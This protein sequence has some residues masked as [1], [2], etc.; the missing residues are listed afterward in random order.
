MPDKPI[1]IFP[2]AIVAARKTLPQSFGPPGPR[3]T[4][5]QQRARLANRFQALSQQFGTVQANAGG[6]DP[7]QVVVFETVGSVEDFQRVVKRIPGMEWLGDF[8][9]EIAEPDPGF[10][11]DGQEQPSMPGRLFVLAG[12]R[13]AYNEVLRLWRAWSRDPNEKLPRPYGSLATVFKHLQDVRPWE[14]KDR[15]A[16][17]GV[18]AS[19]ERGLTSNDPAIRFEAELW[20][21]ADPAK[22][23]EA[24]ARFQTTVGEAGGQCIKQAIFPEIDYH[25]V[26]LELPATAVRQTVA[27][28]NAGNYTKLLRLTDVKYFTPFGQAAIMPSSD[29]SPTSAARKTLPTGDP[30]AALLDGLPLTNHAV[31]QGRL[32]VDDPDNLAAQYQAGEHRHG[33][34]MAS[35]ITHGELDANEPAISSKLY[36]RPLM[37]PGRPDASN[38]RWETFP[39]DELALDI[40]HRA[41]KRI[42]E[43]DDDEP[44]QASSVKVI[45]LSL[46]DTFQPFDRQLSPWARLLDWLAWKYQVLFVVSAGNHPL[47]VSIPVPPNAVAGMADDDLRGH[48]LRAMAHQKVQRR[49][50]APAESVNAL[51]V[52]ALHAQAT[53]PVNAGRLVDLLRGSGFPSPVN[54]V[55]SGY[56]RAIK[57]EILVP[58][59]RQHHSPKLLG[60]PSQTAEFEIP[61]AISQ[62]G[63]SVAAPGGTAVPPTNAVRTVGTSN[64]AALTTRRAAQFVDEIGQLRQEEGGDL[65]SDTYTAVILKAM[66][67][68]GATWGNWQTF[69][70]QTF[71]GPDNGVERWWRIKRACAQFFGYGMAD[72]ER[73]TICTDQRVIVLGCGELSADQGHVYQVPIPPALN[74]Q[75]IQRRT[76]VTLAWMTP[77]NP[78][79]RNYCMADLWFDLPNSEALQIKRS[80]ASDKM[81]RQG[82][83]QHELFEGDAAVPI[84][85]GDTL[86][87]HVSCRSDAGNKLTTPIPYA[88]M[89]SLETSRPLAVSVYEQVK[90]ALD[91]LRAAAR[92]RSGVRAGRPRR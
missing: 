10:L 74:A 40:V 28:I 86:S 53:A 63:Q 90:V 19:W 26:L 61:R 65:L 38:R 62:P 47:D 56:R 15:I 45:N 82:T 57:P 83:V 18:V 85:E 72:F 3:P 75:R 7:E 52:A 51:T 37:C 8:E 34:A 77:T 41:V 87:I 54:C 50:L 5:S 79:H 68:H 30:V 44:A 17:T 32:V 21:R 42:M 49:L 58:G 20:C 35:L 9:A 2:A 43:G 78:R 71:D 92:V 16:T 23:N 59:G 84:A 6:V 36:V 88:L 64:A 25:G 4:Q 91:R 73:G 60:S 66:L 39:Q 12:N 46:G 1:L 69:I 14:P 55:A 33:T 11:M 70:D 48:V 29:G 13:T 67:V 76:T 27:S 80:D 31:L 89:A 24:Y 81:V 22:R